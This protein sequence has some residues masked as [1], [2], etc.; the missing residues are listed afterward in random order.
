MAEQVVQCV[1]GSSPASSESVVSMGKTLHPHCLDVVRVGVTIGVAVKVGTREGRK[2]CPSLE[3]K[4]L[5]PPCVC[6]LPVPQT[7]N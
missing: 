4:S 5:M 6:A 1:G 7:F 3:I 2:P